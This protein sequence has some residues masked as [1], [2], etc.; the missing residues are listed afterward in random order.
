[1]A[2]SLDSEAGC[3]EVWVEEVGEVREMLPEEVGRGEMA[4][5]DYIMNRDERIRS[6][7]NSLASRNTGGTHHRL[8]G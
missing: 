5:D 1:L 2:D 8:R 7:P 3:A 6:G 4:V